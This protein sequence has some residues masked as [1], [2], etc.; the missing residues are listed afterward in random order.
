MDFSNWT[1]EDFNAFDARR[2]E[3]FQPTAQ[4]LAQAEAERAA[5]FRNAVNAKLSAVGVTRPQTVTKEFVVAFLNS[6]DAKQFVGDDVSGWVDNQIALFENNIG[7]AFDELVV[8]Y[9]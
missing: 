8:R 7:K 4:E 2:N 1:R 3:V 9:L 6:I 5:A